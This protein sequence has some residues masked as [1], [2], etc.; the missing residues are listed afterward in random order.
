MSR[1]VKLMPNYFI[2]NKTMTVLTIVINLT[3][4]CSNYN[5]VDCIHVAG[6]HNQLISSI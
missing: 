4:Q 2:W 5:D 3:A 1:F 6:L